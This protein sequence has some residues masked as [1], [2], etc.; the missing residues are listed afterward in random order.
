MQFTLF[1]SGYKL[2]QYLVYGYNLA[3]ASRQ[4]GLHKLGQHIMHD[5][6]FEESGLNQSAGNFQSLAR[7]INM[8]LL[9][10][11]PRADRSVVRQSKRVFTTC[12]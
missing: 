11:L 9:R 6:A 8:A 12:T 2:I 4:R 5:G 7:L 3:A 10:A 1:P